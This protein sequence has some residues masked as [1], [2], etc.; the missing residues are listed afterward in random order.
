MEKSVY[1]ASE[2]TLISLSG[3]RTSG[4]LLYK[5][6]Q[7]YGGQLPD[8]IKVIFANTGKEL[9]E[10]LDFVRDI[11]ANWRV[12]VT[13]VEYGGRTPIK[14]SK[15]YDY[16][17]NVVDYKTAS[18]NGEPFSQLLIDVKG[19]PNPMSRYCSGQLKIRTMTRYLQSIGWEKGWNCFIG[20][21]ADE[22]RRAAK[23]HNKI[24]EGQDYFCPLYL[25]KVTKEDVGNF[26]ADNSF[27]LNLPNNN[28][29][30]DWGNCDLCFLKAKNK[31]LSIIQ[32]RP[33]LAQWWIDVEEKKKDQFDRN[34]WKYSQM[35][36]IAS[37]QSSLFNYGNESIPC[38]CGD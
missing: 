10:T 29:T 13:W 6:L 12:P 3:G 17:V 16:K 24:N 11:E 37:S 36:V 2:N 4:F 21:R 31:R 28:G 35:K 27:D 20:I 7:E 33:D 19:L 30:T 18:R 14:D 26:W 38:F 1:R 22:P 25:D 8:N 15:N 5:T 9:P 23:L 34:G 32:E